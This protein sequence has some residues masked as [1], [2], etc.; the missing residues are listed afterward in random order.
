MTLGLEHSQSPHRFA[1]TVAMERICSLLVD[2]A[3][4]FDA[5]LSERAI[6][7]AIGIGR[8]PVREAL[9]DLA[10]EGIVSVEPGRG[11]FLRR[12]D[13]PEVMELLEV[14]LAIEGM[15]VRLAA[16]KGFVGD[17][18]QI[19]ATLHSLTKRPFAGE[20]IREAEAI[21]DRVHGT[22]VQGAGNEILNSLYGGLRLRIGISLRLVQRRE[23]DRIRETVDEH[24]AIAEAVLARSADLAV[25]LLH[26]HLRRGHAITIA[27]FAQS[28]PAPTAAEAAAL[29][30]A[31]ARRRGR[32]P[33]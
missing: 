22:I 11:T 4:P 17:L 13:A 15:A 7:E 30:P 5:P 33:S 3:V 20:R 32:P 31:L 2:G 14:R 1:R 9:R 28:R 29:K 23:D 27:N 6:A 26:D 19:I 16:E 25:Q 18:P 8:M 21:G 12:L 24:L 10:R